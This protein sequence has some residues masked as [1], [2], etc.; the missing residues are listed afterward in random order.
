MH[1][2]KCDKFC[3]SFHFAWYDSPKGNGSISDNVDFKKHLIF[4]IHIFLFQ[5][6]YWQL[7]RVP[8]QVQRY[9]EFVQDKS[10]L[11]EE[12]GW[13]NCEIWTE[14]PPGLKVWC[15]QDEGKF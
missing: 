14:K 7:R 11:R 8:L 5:A 9:S 6:R 2:F 10:V 3:F 13:W 12:N 1:L 15:Q 4:W